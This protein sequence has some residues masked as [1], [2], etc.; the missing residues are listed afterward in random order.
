[1]TT[2][3][4]PS[5]DLSMVPTDLP[6][7]NATPEEVLQWLSKD[8]ARLMLALG[9]VE[10]AE[11]DPS[12]E[13]LLDDLRPW[14]RNDV[15]MPPW[16]PRPGESRIAY[17]HFLVYLGLEP[18]QRGL[19]A[20]ADAVGKSLS[21][22]Q[23]QSSANK[24][25]ARAAAYDLAVLEQRIR[26]EAA[27]QAK[28][29][30]G[31]SEHTRVL[32]QMT[33]LAIDAQFERDE[34]GRPIGL[35]ERPRIGDMLKLMDRSQEAAHAFLEPPRP[36]AVLRLIFMAVWDAADIFSKA[37]VAMETAFEV[38]GQMTADEVKSRLRY[39]R[40]MIER[41]FRA[42]LRPLLDRWRSDVASEFSAPHL[43]LPSDVLELWQEDDED[44][45]E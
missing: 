10:E 38:E 11:D 35:V 41:Q 7:E 4:E 30:T 20:V 12:D 23:K 22:I 42:E 15:D 34:A 37:I 40:S 43:R 13:A 27:N 32:A 26:I 18:H 36:E 25:V 1:M 39:G 5:T 17:A 3:I 16:A 29:S 33:D 14:L 28:V 31:L 6:D 2:D 8:P 21:A 45:L 44:D 24:W 19:W 9:S